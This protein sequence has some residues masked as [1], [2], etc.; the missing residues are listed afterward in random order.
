LTAGKHERRKR[1]G[2]HPDEE[3]EALHGG[4]AQW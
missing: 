4:V 3:K 2:S 1:P